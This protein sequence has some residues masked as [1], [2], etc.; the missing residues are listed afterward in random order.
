MIKVSMISKRKSLVSGVVV[1]QSL[2]LQKTLYIHDPF[3]QGDSI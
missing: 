1:S 3:L 2:N